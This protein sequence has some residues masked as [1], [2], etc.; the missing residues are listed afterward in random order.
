MG[1]SRLPKKVLMDIEGTTSLRFMIDRV[2]KSTLIDKT[3]VAT[4]NDER[5]DQIVK[6]CNEK[7][8]IPVV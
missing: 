1:S 5:D 3:I 7:F 8:P 4:T 2:E 6:F